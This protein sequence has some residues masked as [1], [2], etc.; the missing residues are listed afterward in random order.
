MKLYNVLYD[1]SALFI[2][3]VDISFYLIKTVLYFS[4]I[5]CSEKRKKFIE[6]SIF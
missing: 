3:V 1:K 2:P 5:E 6:W 4:E